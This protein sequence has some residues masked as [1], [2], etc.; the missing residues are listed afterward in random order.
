ML[1]AIVIVI[2]TKLLCIPT[3]SLGKRGLDEGIKP[4]KFYVLFKVANNC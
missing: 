4:I 1:T 2:M 3:M